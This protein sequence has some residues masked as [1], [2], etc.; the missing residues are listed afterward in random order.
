M[1]ARMSKRS[2]V[3]LSSCDQ[4]GRMSLLGLFTAFIDIAGEHGTEIGLGMEDLAKKNLFWLAVKTKVKFF[5][6]PALMEPISLE[7]WPEKPGRA[8]CRRYYALHDAKNLAA[9]G[10]TEWAMVDKDSGKL[11][12]LAAVYPEGLEHC[13]EKSCEGPFARIDADFAGGEEVGRYTVRSTD[14]DVG[15]HMNNVAYVRMLL[16]MFSCAELALG[17]PVGME[18]AYRRPCLE[19]EELVVYRRSVEK[20]WELGVVKANGEVAALA[21]IEFE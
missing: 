20:A 3:Y 11:Q 1:Y 6:R 16:G 14:I 21:R 17:E 10:M 4:T 7:T 2:K 18:I 12:K 5:R 8:S 15:Q 19:G 9:V 13:E